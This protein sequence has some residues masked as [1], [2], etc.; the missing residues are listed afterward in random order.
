MNSVCTMVS[1]FFTTFFKEDVTKSFDVSSIDIH[2]YE[3][4]K[5]MYVCLSKLLIDC[6]YRYLALVGTLSGKW[7]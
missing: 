7:Q 5:A 3:A 2:I 4:L 1:N 6:R